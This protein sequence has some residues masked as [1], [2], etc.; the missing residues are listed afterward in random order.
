MGR[1]EALEQTDRP[2]LGAI[3]G[4]AVATTAAAGRSRSLIRWFSLGFLCACIGGGVAFLALLLVRPADAKP[5][6]GACGSMEPVIRSGIMP[7]TRQL[8]SMD[9]TGSRFARVE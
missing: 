8:W 5:N 4:R 3:A 1:L 2:G 6:L 7:E 9:R